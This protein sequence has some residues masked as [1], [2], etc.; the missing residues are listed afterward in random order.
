ML[1]NTAPYGQLA[2]MCNIGVWHGFYE[3]G[4]Y[5]DFVDL[6]GEAL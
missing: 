3:F 1:C 2:R 4:L 5:S 6:T